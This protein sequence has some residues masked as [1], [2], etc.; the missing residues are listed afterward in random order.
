MLGDLVRAVSKW[1]IWQ[2]RLRWRRSE[3]NQSLDEII[4]RLGHLDHRLS[5]QNGTLGQNSGRFDRL[6]DAISRVSESLKEV[7][8]RLDRTDQQ[9]QSIG[10][11]LPAFL[12]ALDRLPTWAEKEM[13]DHD[14]QLKQIEETRNQLNQLIERLAQ[15]RGRTT[16]TKPAPPT[17]RKRNMPRRQLETR[18]VTGRRKHD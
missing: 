14:V 13:Q 1:P 4:N 9:V 7:R 15:S 6:D 17:A 2:R 12:K 5:F 8:G 16:D 3:E 11:A 18:K 10:A